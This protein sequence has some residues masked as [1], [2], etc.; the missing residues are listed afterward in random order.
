[1]G[2]PWG[3]TPKFTC[4]ST[5]NKVFTTILLFGFIVLCFMF[6]FFSS[7]FFFFVFSLQIVWPPLLG[8]LCLLVSWSLSLL[9][10]LSPFL[11]SSAIH[12]FGPSTSSGN[13][14]LPWVLQTAGS[15]G[16]NRCFLALHLAS[17]I[18]LGS[19]KW[20]ESP[21]LLGIIYR[22]CLHLV[23]TGLGNRQT[24]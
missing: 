6:L 13:F 16:G 10:P 8:A 12:A 9:Q 7:W 15:S 24:S 18:L 22:N 21:A 2:G 11:S 3:N 14:P 4:F 23:F 5:A 19:F 1:M 20:Q 17:V